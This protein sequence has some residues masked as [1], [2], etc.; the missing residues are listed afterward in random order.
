VQVCS[1]RLLKNLDMSDKIEGRKELIAGI[2]H[3]AWLLEIKDKDGNDLYPEI[4]K[5][6]PEKMLD[7]DFKD[8]VRLD[9]I[10]HFGYYCTESSEHNAEYNPFYIKS[11][12]PE[13]IE[14]YNIPLDEYPRR[15]VDQIEKWKTDYAE[16]QKS[17]VTLNL[18]WLEYC[19]VCRTNGDIPYQLTQFKKYYRDY[20]AK[21]NATMH[22]N[23]KF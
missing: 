17:G 3:M 5:R 6:V 1:E 16:M 10:N 13:L 14:K 20:T 11:K 21:T 7:P 23:H 2:N 15:C 4:K 8:K 12:Y 9:Y 22:L 18:L 19:E